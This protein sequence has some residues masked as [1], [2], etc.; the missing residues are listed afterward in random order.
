MTLS[1]C[2][3]SINYFKKLDSSAKPSSIRWVMNINEKVLGSKL[4]A[5]FGKK[6]ILGCIWCEKNPSDKS[7]S[8]KYN[9]I[10]WLLFFNRYCS[11]KVKGF[12]W[13]LWPYY[14]HIQ[15]LFSNQGSSL[16]LSQ[17]Y[18]IIYVNENFYESWYS[19]HKQKY[20]NINQDT[21]NTYSSRALESIALKKIF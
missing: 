12:L 13:S 11:F 5:Q 6:C 1:I 19:R 3:K 14:D 17:Y 2:N 8:S 4:D 16:S 18:L 20:G 9:N 10:Y 15:L 21:K 7:N